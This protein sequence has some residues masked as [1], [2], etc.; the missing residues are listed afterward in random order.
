MVNLMG[1]FHCW[2]NFRTTSVAGVS[3]PINYRHTY[4]WRN[5]YIYRERERARERERELKIKSKKILYHLKVPVTKINEHTNYHHT[6]T[7]TIIY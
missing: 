1:E 3:H 6:D 7:V 2:Q 5:Y 4:N